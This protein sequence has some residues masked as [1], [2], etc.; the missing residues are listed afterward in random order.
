[1]AYFLVSK[2]GVSGIVHAISGGVQ[3]CKVTQ[4]NLGA[5]DFEVNVQWDGEVCN[6]N[7][8]TKDLSETGEPQ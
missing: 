1:M 8:T 6:V 7:A 4:A 2:G 3:Y 5:T